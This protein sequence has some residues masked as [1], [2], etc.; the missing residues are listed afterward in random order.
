MSTGGSTG[1]GGRRP[2]PGTSSPGS[3]TSTMMGGSSNPLSGLD[4]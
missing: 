1:G 3:D 4:F 2:R